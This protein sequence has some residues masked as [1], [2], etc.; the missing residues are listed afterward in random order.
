MLRGSPGA[1][2]PMHRPASGPGAP[3]HPSAQ[4]SRAGGP[5]PAGGPFA[6]GGHAVV[7]LAP[8]QMQQMQHQMPPMQQMQHQMP[9]MQQMQ[10][11]TPPM[12]Q[13][14]H[15]MPSPGPISARPVHAPMAHVGA[16]RDPRAPALSTFASPAQNRFPFQAASAAGPLLP[17]P[18]RCH[19]A[20]RA[21]SVRPA[22]RPALTGLGARVPGAGQMA[23][24]GGGRRQPVAPV[25]AAPPYSE[26][27]SKG[28]AGAR[29]FG[30]A[31]P[32]QEP[33]G[34]PR[35]RPAVAPPQQPNAVA[36]RGGSAPHARA[37][38][39][40][41]QA[42]FLSAGV[43]AAPAVPPQS[44]LGGR[45]ASAAGAA[46]RHDLLARQGLSSEPPRRAPAARG[47]PARSAGAGRAAEGSLTGR[48]AGRDVQALLGEGWEA[49]EAL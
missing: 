9:P 46:A 43:S 37:P 38:S 22:A 7:P 1:G 33:A 2:A 10:H 16:R 8:D 47:A 36:G 19:R 34:A 49:G 21:G 15:Q 20:P 30:S 39:A 29:W 25:R 14:Q 28:G 3:L 48:A 5:S 4:A 24:P 13:M 18:R 26:N 42:A 12:Q 41:A 40:F 11:Q 27:G 45:S 23:S 32:P 31:P 17:A 35:A 6:G 44:S